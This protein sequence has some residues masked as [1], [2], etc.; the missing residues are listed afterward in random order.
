M[1]GGGG[2]GAKRFGELCVPLKKSWLRRWR[3]QRVPFESGDFGENGTFCKNGEYS[4]K[5]LQKWSMFESEILKRFESQIETETLS[6]YSISVCIFSVSS[7]YIFFIFV[8]FQEDL[9]LHLFVS[10]VLN[11]CNLWFTFRLYLY[12]VSELVKEKSEVQF[13][14]TTVQFLFP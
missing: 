13:P 9:D 7:M 4:P 12:L 11:F 6:R 2:G 8:V 5:S 10:Q 14:Y 1:G 3:Q